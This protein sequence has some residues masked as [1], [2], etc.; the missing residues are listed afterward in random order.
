MR[1]TLWRWKSYEVGTAE[2]DSLFSLLCSL[3]T[4]V[5]IAYGYWRREQDSK[6]EEKRERA[7]EH[8]AEVKKNIKREEKIGKQET[9]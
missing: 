3:T 8:A 7:S 6:H 1:F 2:R 5:P 9:D 4:L